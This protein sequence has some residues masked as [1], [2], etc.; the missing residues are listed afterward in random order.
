MPQLAL[1]SS[2]R[3]RR[4]FL[5]ATA[6]GAATLAT[7][8][9]AR[10][11][12]VKPARVILDPARTLA[13]LDRRLFGSFLEHIGRAIYGGIFEPDSKLADAHGFRKDVLEAIRS[14]DVP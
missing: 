10:A 2:P 4:Q 12:T 14:L 11:A 13:T 6:S 8:P 7:A 1:A 9:L 5:R 3:S